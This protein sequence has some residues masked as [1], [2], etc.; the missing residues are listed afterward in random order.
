MDGG[1]PPHGGS[2]GTEFGVPGTRGGG[3]GAPHLEG[4]GVPNLGSRAPGPAGALGLR[5]VRYELGTLGA[6]IGVPGTQFGGTGVV[7]RDGGV[8][9]CVLR[10]K[11]TATNQFRHTNGTIFFHEIEILEISVLNFRNSISQHRR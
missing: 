5:A 1:D 9:I 10:K 2:G 4:P 8:G 7:P 6:G 11:E 3:S